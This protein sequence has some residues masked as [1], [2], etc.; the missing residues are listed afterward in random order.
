[1][2]IQNTKKYHYKLYIYS[3]KWEFRRIA[4]V[5]ADINLTGILREGLFIEKGWGY[6]EVI[7]GVI[8]EF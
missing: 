5:E 8:Y 2:K 4:R 3:D 7:W 6:D 1:M